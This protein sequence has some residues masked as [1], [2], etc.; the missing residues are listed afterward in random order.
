MT[1]SFL[2]SLLLLGFI[3]STVAI[4]DISITAGVWKTW[5]PSELTI[6]VGTRVCWNG[7]L[8]AGQQPHNVAESGHNGLSGHNVAQTTGSGSTGNRKAVY[9]I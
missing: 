9:T 3:T 5:I 8:Q 1:R 2:S 4:C 7:L 6:V